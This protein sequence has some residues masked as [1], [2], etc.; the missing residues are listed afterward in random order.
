M[1]MPM[2]SVNH[3]HTTVQIV[4]TQLTVTLAQ[5]TESIYQLVL[6]HK[7]LMM[8]KDKLFAQLVNSLVLPVLDLLPIV[9]LVKES[10]PLLHLAHVQ[11][12]T[13]LK[14]NPT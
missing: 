1:K 5:K 8:L 9:L 14:L 10:E 3:V 12:V 11:V 4:P 7:V 13:M 2:N 6:A